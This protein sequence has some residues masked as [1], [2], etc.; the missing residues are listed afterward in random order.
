MSSGGSDQPS[1][2]NNQKKGK[3]NYV[4]KLLSR[5]N[6]QNPSSSQPNTPISSSVHGSIPPVADATQST[7]PVQDAIA[8]T[9]SPHVGSN[10]ST[11]PDITPSPYTN[12]GG[13]HS[14]SAANN[15]ENEVLSAGDRPLI[16]PIG[17]G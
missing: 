11:P 16:Q 4:I 1:L 3:K 6:N 14:A 5:F 12:L 15:L 17:G 13:T 7:P 10:T 2:S 9:P 8:S